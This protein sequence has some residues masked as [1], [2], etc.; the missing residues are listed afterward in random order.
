[1][2]FNTFQRIKGSG[3]GRVGGGAFIGFDEKDINKEFER[4]FKELEKLHDDVTTAQIRRIARASLKPMLKAYRDGITDF[5]SSSASEKGRK[6]PRN[7]FVVYRNGSVFAEITKGQLKKS[8]GIITTRVNKGDTFASLQV[9]PRVKRSFKDPEKGG[10]FAHFIEYGFLNNGRYNGVNKGF[11]SKARAQNMSGVG[12]EFKR[13]M[14][15]FLNKKVKAA[16]Q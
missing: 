11:A 5:P 15:S 1:M 10:W 14:R 7:K 12:N 6:K 9:G 8:M 3:H 16:K 13:R 2:G 4:A